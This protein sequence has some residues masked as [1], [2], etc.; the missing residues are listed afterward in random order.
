MNRQ[1]KHGVSLVYGDSGQ[2]DTPI[3]AGDPGHDDDPF[4]WAVIT[5]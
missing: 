5:D 4:G 2:A 1:F 3:S